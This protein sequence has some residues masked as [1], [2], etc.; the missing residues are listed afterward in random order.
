ME[1]SSNAGP[2]CQHVLWA[3][4]VSSRFGHSGP[5]CAGRGLGGEGGPSYLGLEEG[6]GGID[7]VLH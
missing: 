4:L 1:R 5:V 2:F 7:Q 6:K 3:P